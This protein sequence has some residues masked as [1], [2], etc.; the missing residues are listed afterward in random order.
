MAVTVSCNE[1]LWPLQENSKGKI[2]EYGS[3]RLKPKSRYLDFYNFGHLNTPWCTVCCKC[4][5]IL[6]QMLFFGAPGKYRDSLPRQCLMTG[7]SF[8]VVS[9]FASLCFAIQDLQLTVKIGLCKS[10]QL[11]LLSIMWTSS[12]CVQ[13]TFAFTG[14]LS[15]TS[16][17]DTQVSSRWSNNNSLR[18]L[19]TM[20]YFLYCH[21][22]SGL[23][24]LLSLSQVFFT[25]CCVTYLTLIFNAQYL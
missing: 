6:F 25:F 4:E 1:R 2:D 20:I 12:L 22:H 19:A 17:T 10:V 16:T 21:S 9:P 14:I 24:F 13:D 7:I 23:L 15:S 5:C 8:S 11:H 18:I 3:N